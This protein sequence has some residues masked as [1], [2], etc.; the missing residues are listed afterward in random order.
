MVMVEDMQAMF[1]E[2]FLI[3]VTIYKLLFTLF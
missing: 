1:R 2:P 3:I